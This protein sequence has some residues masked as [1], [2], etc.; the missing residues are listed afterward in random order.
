MKLGTRDQYKSAMNKY[1]KYCLVEVCHP[2]M[3]EGAQFDYDG[4]MR[5]CR[6]VELRM[7]G[8]MYWATTEGGI[9]PKTAYQYARTVAVSER[10]Q[11]GIDLEQREWK[12]LKLLYS[13]LQAKYP[14][15][16]RTRL[17]LVQQ[18]YI[19]MWRVL[20]R[21]T[22]VSRMFKAFILTMFQAVCRFSDLKDVRRSDISKRDGVI[23][24]TIREHKTSHHT[25][26]QVF[27]TKYL[28]M[29]EKV[30]KLTFNLSAGLALEDYIRLDPF[31]SA[32]EP[33]R[34][35][36]LFRTEDKKALDY[37]QQLRWLRKLLKATGKDPMLYGLHSPRIGGAT[38]AMMSSG[39]NEFVV[40]QM[41]FWKGKSVRLYARP[42]SEL[43]VGIQRGMM[44]TASTTLC[45]A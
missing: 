22:R 18:D 28:T 37:D 42:T 15:K 4:T 29:P 5:M 33:L 25:G 17:P 38:C 13:R 39:G 34:D 31:E 12:N 7:M 43:I 16:V 3:V 8:F 9:K 14:H 1:F 30:S 21:E 45:T 10:K 32:S 6:M 27:D 44:Q 24:I 35:Q 20:G 36:F 2:S 19:T 23:K 41:G 11:S 40:K 26:G